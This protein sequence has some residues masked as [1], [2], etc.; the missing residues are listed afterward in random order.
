MSNSLNPISDEQA[1]V[2]QEV[3]EKAGVAL[4]LVEEAGG[5]VGWVLGT[6]PTD[7]LG[8]VEDW[9]VQARIRNLAR[10]AHKTEEILSARGTTETVHA[11]PSLAVPLL[12]GAMDESR[13]ELADLWA[14]LLANA[15]DPKLGTV[16]YEFIDAVK[17]MNADEAV[18]FK[19]MREKSIMTIHPEKRG[20][21]DQP[22]V[23][24]VDGLARNLGMRREASEISVRRL[25]ELGFFDPLGNSARIISAF[26]HE[27]MRACYPRTD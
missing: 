2:L 19:H 3:A 7:L 15:I 24:N 26:C 12:R 23:I 25:D 11:S 6:A 13:E 9:L 20:P 4:E 18:V 21:P 14:R 5:Y 16:R 27:F 10:M 8:V 17:G 1:K 22:G